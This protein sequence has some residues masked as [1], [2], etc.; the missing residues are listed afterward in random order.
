MAVKLS[1][2]QWWANLK[3]NPTLKSQIFQEIDLNQWSKSQI[4][5]FP[6]ISNLL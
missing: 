5:I 4:P 3:S 1:E 2:D 6:Q